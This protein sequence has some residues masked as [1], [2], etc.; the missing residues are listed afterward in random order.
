MV[1]LWAA[2]SV[3]AY[4]AHCDYAVLPPSIVVFTDIVAN[5]GVLQRPDV[6][7]LAPD[8]EG[9]PIIVMGIVVLYTG[10]RTSTQLEPSAVAAVPI[11][12]MRIVELDRGAEPVPQH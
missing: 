8:H 9:C 5:Q 1:L 2:G 3:A 6:G 11:R 10:Y 12:R 4:A 7:A